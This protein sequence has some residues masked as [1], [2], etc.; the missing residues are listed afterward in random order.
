M[1]GPSFRHLT[2]ERLQ[3]KQAIEERILGWSARRGPAAPFISPLDAAASKSRATLSI[4]WVG[5]S[6]ARLTAPRWPEGEVFGNS[7]VKEF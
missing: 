6:G 3:R 1:P 4:V 2:L 7:S 5:E